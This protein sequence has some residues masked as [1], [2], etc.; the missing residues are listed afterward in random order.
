M[1]ADLPQQLR[2]P[3]RSVCSSNLIQMSGTLVACAVTSRPNQ[4]LVDYAAL[5]GAAQP[6]SR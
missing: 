4:G 6:I 1:H 2:M 3:T 5:L